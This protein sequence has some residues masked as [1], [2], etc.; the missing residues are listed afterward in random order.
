MVRSVMRRLP[1]THWLRAF[2]AAA[3]HLSF[4]GAARELHVTQ[5]AVSQQVRLLEHHLQSPLF[6]RLPRSLQLTE[7]GEAYLPVVQE[8]F[9]RVAARTQELF[10][11]ASERVLAVK[12]NASFAALWLAP[13]LA[14]FHARHP[15]IAIR[16]THTMWPSDHDLADFDLSIRYGSGRWSGLQ[17]QRLTRETR[18]PVCAPQL[19]RGRHGLYGPRDL[20]RFPLIHVLG[21]EIG[22]SQWL[23]AAAVAESIDTGQGLQLEASFVAYELAAAGAGVA[24]AH[25]SLAAGLLASGRLVAPFGP[26]VASREG[27][28]LV[29]P[30]ARDVTAETTVFRDWLLSES[31]AADGD[32]AGHEIG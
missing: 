20:R 26:A 27:F 29:L 21:N 12:A 32:S 14:R 3:R 19:C 7:V 17:A 22:W 30:K 11:S 5:S 13:R 15:Q 23:Q 18:F 31:K 9:E 4:T 28:F 6:R 10:G 1:P 16:F 24:L 2:E 25:R 8:A